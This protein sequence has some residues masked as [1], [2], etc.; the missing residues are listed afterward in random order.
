[1]TMSPYLVPI[2]NVLGKDTQARKITMHDVVSYK[3][4]EPS[5]GVQMKESKRSW[6][7][8]LVP[9]CQSMGG[10]REDESEEEIRSVSVPRA[11][12]ELVEGA[13]GSPAGRVLLRR[14]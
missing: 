10:K 14:D 12:R 3:G 11:Q 1:M 6:N 7:P 13:G 8:S 9:R 2:S 5:E 4:C